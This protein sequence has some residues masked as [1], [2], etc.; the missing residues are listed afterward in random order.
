MV[1][2]RRY[3]PAHRCRCADGGQQ[4][5]QHCN[6]DHFTL[7]NFKGKLWHPADP[8]DVTQVTLSSRLGPLQLGNGRHGDLVGAR[9]ILVENGSNI[10]HGMAGD[11]GDLRVGALRF[12]KPGHGGATQIVKMQAGDFGLVAGTPPRGAKGVRLPRQ[13]ALVGEDY[14]AFALGVV[15]D[16]AQP[17]GH[18][19]IDAAAGLTLALVFG[20]S[21][22]R[23]PVRRLPAGGWSDQVASR[24]SC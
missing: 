23:A 19:H 13:P 8:D 21:S 11:A 3:R 5:D 9:E 4:G 10:V 22:R 12:G 16:G 17:T 24:D 6:F 18:R 7:Q 15:E 2:R 1:R 20:P 14:G